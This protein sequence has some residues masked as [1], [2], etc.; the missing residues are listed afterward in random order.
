[1]HHIASRFL[2]SFIPQILKVQANNGEVCETGHQLW[3][4]KRNHLEWSSSPLARVPGQQLIGKVL[5]NSFHPVCNT[6]LG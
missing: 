4:K 2:D 5:S 6:K 1:M 3:M